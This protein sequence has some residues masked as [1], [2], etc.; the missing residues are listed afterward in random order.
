MTATQD[1]IE[2]IVTVYIVIKV[3]ISDS[4][5]F[6]ISKQGT[7]KSLDSGQTASS[8]ITHCYSIEYF[9]AWRNVFLKNPVTTKVRICSHKRTN[10]DASF[11]A[12]ARRVYRDLSFDLAQFSQK[13]PSLT[14]ASYQYSN[15]LFDLKVIK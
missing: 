5:L 8:N 1:D 14:M 3:L 11:L 7:L 12:G 13:L 9:Q 4:N 2:P 6:H 10:H 15:P